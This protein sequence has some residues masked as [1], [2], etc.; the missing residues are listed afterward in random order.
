MKT[1]TEELIASAGKKGD[2]WKLFLVE[3]PKEQALAPTDLP[4]DLYSRRVRRGDAPGIKLVLRD[5]ATPVQAFAGRLKALPNVPK[6]VPSVVGYRFCVSFSIPKNFE[7]KVPMP[8]PPS[9]SSIRHKISKPSR[10]IQKTA[11]VPIAMPLVL[12]RVKKW[13]LPNF[14]SLFPFA[15]I[16]PD[17]VS[18]NLGIYLCRDCARIHTALSGTQTTNDSVFVSKIR[19]CFY[20]NWPPEMSQIV[21]QIGNGNANK[22][23]EKTLAK[24]GTMKAASIDSE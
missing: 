21:K 22:H 3:G 17:H 14:L 15:L 11:I 16:D 9:P 10:R 23:W 7:P 5:T 4:F 13:T 6:P 18:L 1:T 20:F 12:F 19:P 24:S 8:F 2:K